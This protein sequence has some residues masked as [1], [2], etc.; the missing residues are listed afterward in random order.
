MK[1]AEE[2]CHNEVGVVVVVM[3]LMITQHVLNVGGE[4]MTG[5]GRW[6]AMKMGQTN[7]T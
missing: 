7:E 3:E 2:T 4:I 6:Q 5:C 1:A